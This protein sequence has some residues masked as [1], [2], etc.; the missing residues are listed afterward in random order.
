MAL[1]VAVA[2]MLVVGSLGFG[3]KGVLRGLGGLAGLGGPWGLLGLRVLG[4]L[5]GFGG[6]GSF[7]GVGRFRVGREGESQRAAE[8]R[9]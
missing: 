5:G 3:V 1:A 6:L 7:E 8:L 4:G 2:V 9:R